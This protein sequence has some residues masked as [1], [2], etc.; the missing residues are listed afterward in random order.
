MLKFTVV[1]HACLYVEGDGGSLLFDPWFVGSCYWRSWWNYPEAPEALIARLRPDAIYITHV[2]WDHFQGPSLRRFDR[3]TRILLP[4]TPSPRMVED[5]RDMGYTNVHEIP[6]GTGL[7]LWPG[8]ELYSYQFGPVFADSAAVL[9]DGR[10]T[11]LNLNDAKLFGLPLQ[12]ITRRF[13]NIDFCLRSHSSASPLPYCVEGYE[14]TFPHVRSQAD[15]TEEFTRCCVSVGA[16]FAVPFASNHCFLH[17]ETRKFNRT[18]VNP[19]MVEQHYNAFVAE[20]GLA[21]RCVVMPPGSCWSDTGGFELRE[22]DY[23]PRE[24]HIEQLLAKHAEALDRQY[25]REARAKASLEDTQ[26]YFLK[27]M[28]ALPGVLRRRYVP[29]FLFKVAESA[30]HRWFLID[31]PALAVTE[32]AG[33]VPCDFTIELHAVVL[34]DCARKRMFSSWGAGK[35]LNIVLNPGATDLGK[36]GMLLT[37]LDY[38]ENDGLPLWNNLRPRQ[39]I[40]RMRRWREVV[41]AL[42]L[43]WNHKIRRRPFVVSD[44]YPVSATR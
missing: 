36:V 43:V 38:F 20:R 10:T 30:G 11:L 42:R 14:T 7:T 28:R 8:V 44:L 31:G 29:R 13:P 2:H 27:L 32:V 16:R 1:S 5:L 18:G 19:A 24:E 22:F 3:G 6:H 9:S 12:Q 21:S 23:A 37:L 40:A 26:A 34:N 25:L 4:K 39:L 41:E 17:R 33:P 35:R 15:Y